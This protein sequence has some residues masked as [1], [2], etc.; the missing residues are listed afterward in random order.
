MDVEIIEMENSAI[1]HLKKFLDVKTDKYDKRQSSKN[2]I[3]D[4]NKIE[5]LDKRLSAVEIDLNRIF[6]NY[7]FISYM[8]TKEM[9]KYEGCLKMEA[10]MEDIKRRMKIILLKIYE[11]DYY[12]AEYMYDPHK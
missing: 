12:Y 8:N 10:K 2:L 4:A 11:L 7:S 9:K 1:F 3:D 5:Y 6:N